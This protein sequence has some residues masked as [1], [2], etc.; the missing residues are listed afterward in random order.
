MFSILDPWLSSEYVSN[1]PCQRLKYVGQKHEINGLIGKE[2]TKYCQ[3]LTHSSL[4]VHFYIFW[5]C[6]KTFGVEKEVL[7]WSNGLEWFKKA[8]L[9]ILSQ[10]PLLRGGKWL[11]RFSLCVD[12][13][14]SWLYYIQ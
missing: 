7:K 11:I 1:S 9:Q 2:K 14:P 10:F 6:Q 12:Y 8:K 5:K 13:F 4:V 3:I